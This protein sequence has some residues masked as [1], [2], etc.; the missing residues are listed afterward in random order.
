MGESCDKLLQAP[1]VNWVAPA[2][3]ATEQLGIWKRERGNSDLVFH[4]EFTLPLRT[5][6]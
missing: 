3:D 2:Y 5:P 6:T 1:F 4:A